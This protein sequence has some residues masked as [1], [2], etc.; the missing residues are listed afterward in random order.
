MKSKVVI[1]VFKIRLILHYT[2]HLESQSFQGPSAGPGPRPQF[3]VYAS[4][5]EASILGAGAGG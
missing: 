1:K 2:E 4:A 5:P 3:R